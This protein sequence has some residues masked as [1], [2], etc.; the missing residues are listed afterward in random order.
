M[1]H[2]QRHTNWLDLY[3]AALLE[4]DHQKLF[5]RIELAQKAIHDR[6]RELADHSNASIEERRAIDDALMNLRCLLRQLQQ[7]TGG[8]A[9]A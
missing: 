3:Q 5:D 8:S 7:P 1:N 6:V 4:I 2:T 9:L